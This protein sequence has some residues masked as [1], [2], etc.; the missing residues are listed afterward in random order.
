MEM[1]TVDKI[2]GLFKTKLSGP[3]IEPLE[4]VKRMVLH[5]N[6]DMGVSIV[7]RPNCVFYLMLS[8]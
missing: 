4:V 1:T 6:G 3:L 8:N 2:T 7:R 5:S